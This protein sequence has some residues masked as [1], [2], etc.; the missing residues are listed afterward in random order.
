MYRNEDESEFDVGLRCVSCIMRVCARAANIC[1][2]RK[3]C[4]SGADV[5]VY[6]SDEYVYSMQELCERRGCIRVYVY[7]CTVCK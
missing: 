7:M 2:V 3:N 5:Y 1:T 4:V 6:A